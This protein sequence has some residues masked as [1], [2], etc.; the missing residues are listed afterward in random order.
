MDFHMLY[1]YNQYWQK[2]LFNAIH[3]NPKV[4][5]SMEFYNS[6]YISGLTEIRPLHGLIDPKH[7]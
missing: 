5:V 2:F 4:V 1:I 7:K 3:P 6:L